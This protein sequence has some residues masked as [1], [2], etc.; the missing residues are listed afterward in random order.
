MDFYQDISKRDPAS[1]FT[2]RNGQTNNIS[3]RQMSERKHQVKLNRKSKR[4]FGAKALAATVVAI[5]L[6]T[7]GLPAAQASTYSLTGHVQV[8]EYALYYGTF[9]PHTSGYALYQLTSVSPGVCGSYLGISMYTSAGNATDRLLFQSASSAARNFVWYG[10]AQIPTGMYA[11]EG[12]N[13]GGGYFC[14]Y[15]NNDIYYTAILDL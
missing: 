4:S 15:P 14:D 3:L 6:I 7:T 10:G 2:Y 13:R 12:D 9:R 11:M 8:S 1:D 5:I